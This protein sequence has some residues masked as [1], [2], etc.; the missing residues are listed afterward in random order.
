MRIRVL[1]RRVTA[2]FVLTLVL[3]HGVGALAQ[4]EGSR[5]AK[6]RVTPVYPDLARK[7]NVSGTVKIEVGVAPD[8]TVKQT[9]VIG[10]HPVLVQAAEDAIKKWKFEAGSEATTETVVFKFKTE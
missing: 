10:G 2:A 9:H 4:E 7:M 8:G 5:K 3:L 1:C 6:V